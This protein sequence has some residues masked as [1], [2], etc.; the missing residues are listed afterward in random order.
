M[1][2]MHYRHCGGTMQLIAF[3]VEPAAIV[4]ILDHLVEPSRIRRAEECIWPSG[5]CC[6][7]AR[8]M[9]AKGP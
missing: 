1:G 9:V 6:E 2:V 5:S 7:P 3:I 8:P 4:R